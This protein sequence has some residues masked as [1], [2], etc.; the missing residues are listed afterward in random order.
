MYTHAC[1]ID[2]SITAQNLREVVKDYGEDFNYRL[3]E[4]CGLEF[5]YF[6]SFDEEAIEAAIYNYVTWFPFRSWKNLMSG[7][8]EVGQHE[9]AERVGSKYLHGMSVQTTHHK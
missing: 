1:T 5:T 7:L 8:Q 4:A 6:F 2:P 9:L 3:F